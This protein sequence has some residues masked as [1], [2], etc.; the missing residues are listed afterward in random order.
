MIEVTVGDRMVEAYDSG[1]VESGGL[2]LLWH[3]GTPHT[4]RPL[5]PVLELCASLGV[6]TIT[7]AR[8]GYG[9]S[10]RLIDRDVASVADEVAA[11][12][13]AVGVE[14]VLTM[15]ASGGGP[16]SLACGALLPDRVIAAV[17]LAGIAPY[18]GDESWFAGMA[19]PQA[20]QASVRGRAE[21]TRFAQTAE[22]D[23]AVF[24]EADWAALSGTWSV[25]SADAGAAEQS[26][27]EGGIDDDVAWAGDWG[28]GLDQVRV[29]VWVIHG[30]LDRMVPPSHARQLVDGCPQAELWLRPR[31]GHVSV[32]SALPIALQWL[33]AQAA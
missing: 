27:P 1:P 28:F 14:R 25:L 33:L 6:R 9:R 15:G 21:R 10:T 19:A 17:T 4:G 12:L 8:P 20:L 22:F 16:P 5:P 31:D 32:L 30:G 24:V 2:T 23:P 3:H 26:G 29:P 13:D 7:Y 11:I 18:R